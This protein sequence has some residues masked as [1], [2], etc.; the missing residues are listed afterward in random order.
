LDRHEPP[1]E[2][3]RAALRRSS[4]AEKLGFTRYLSQAFS[5]FRPVARWLLRRSVD[6]LWVFKGIFSK[7]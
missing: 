2:P 6:V 5:L 7:F 4:T 3:W 1:A